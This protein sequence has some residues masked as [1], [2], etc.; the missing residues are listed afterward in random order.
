MEFSLW[1]KYFMD[2]SNRPLASLMLNLEACERKLDSFGGKF[3]YGHLNKAGGVAGFSPKF[4]LFQTE[5]SLWN[6]YFMHISNRS[7]A[8]LMLNLEACEME[9]DSFGGKFFYGHL[10]KA[11]G[12]AG[13][14]PKFGLF[15][16][17]F[18]LWNKYFMHISN[19]SLA[20][21]ML[22]LEACERKLDSF[23]RKIGTLNKAGLSQN[24]SVCLFV[25]I[26]DWLPLPYW[27]RP[28]ACPLIE[29]TEC[30]NRMKCY[31]WY[32]T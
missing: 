1:N 3:F 29:W 5:F 18:S 6:K 10:N 24:W 14:F 7:L 32:W 26:V 11:G 21:L 19:R 31:I 4:G 23:L 22:H 17:E 15:Q 8:S 20:S 28:S 9:L 2:I 13:F 12:V 16:T 25:W 30:H 27:F